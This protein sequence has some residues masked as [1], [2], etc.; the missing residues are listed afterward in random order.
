MMNAGWLSAIR[1][2]SADSLLGHAVWEVV[3]LPL[4]TLW[5]E[6]PLRTVAIAALHCLGGDL[7]IASAVLVA[8]P[9]LA[10]R[11]DWPSVGTAR[12]A[13]LVIIFG[14]AYMVS[15]SR[16]PRLT[17]WL[18][19]GTC[20]DGVLKLPDCPALPPSPRPRSSG[21]ALRCAR[22]WQVTIRPY[23]KRISACSSIRSW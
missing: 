2:C 12:V 15:G 5:Q 17:A 16:F 9:A 23:A 1:R 18:S 21:S 3:Q 19:G 14:C 6:A 4:F 7:A 13:V 11:H 8:A 20:L 10:G 22:R